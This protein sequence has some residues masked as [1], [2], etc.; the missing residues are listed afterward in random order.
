MLISLN[1]YIDLWNTVSFFL[2]FNG[3]GIFKIS[4][5]EKSTQRNDDRFAQK[6]RY[7]LVHCHVLQ[8]H[9]GRRRKNKKYRN[10]VEPT[11]LG[12][13]YLFPRYKHVNVG[14]KNES[15]FYFKYNELCCGFPPTVANIILRCI[16]TTYRSDFT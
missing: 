3:S 4:N 10:L 14:V 7:V 6:F 2:I 16:S 5:N 9:K 11:Y 1:P 12:K 13:N 8:K 15:Q